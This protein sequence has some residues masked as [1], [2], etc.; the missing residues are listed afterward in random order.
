VASALRRVVLFSSAIGSFLFASSAWAQGLQAFPDAFSVPFGEPLVVEAFGVLAND[1]LDG[2]PAEE[3]GATAELVSD[4]SHGV[5]A[6]ASDGSFTYPPGA[7]FDGLDSF[8]Y[9]AVVGVE[10]SEAQVDLGACSGGP[11][12]FV[13]WQ[14]AAFLAKAATLGH[15]SFVEGFEDDAVWGAAR[16]PSSELVVASQGVEWRANP[17][18]PTHTLPPWPPD[19]DPNEVSTSSGAAHSGSWGVYSIPHGYATGTATACDVDT[20]EAH[21]LFHDGVAISPVAGGGPFFGAGGYV[22]GT[23]GAN[24]GFV[25]DGDWANPIALGHLTGGSEF[26]G[27]IDAGPTGLSELQFR[28]LDGKVGQAFFIFLDDVHVLAPPP[29]PPPVPSMG[30]A[31]LLALAGVLGLLGVRF[32]ATSRARVS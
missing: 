30:P 8:V 14:E 26:F 7:S 11:Q 4:V 17:I 28:E 15:P 12:T 13:C 21:C 20:P 25:V 23:F 1:E 32:V 10:T 16:T 24:V 31:A 27:L 5:L 2:E 29:P 9:R 18:D 6:L 22:H 19:P 3:S